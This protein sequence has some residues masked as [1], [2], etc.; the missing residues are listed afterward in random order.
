MN[1][2]RFNSGNRHI[3]P[4]FLEP[5]DDVGEDALQVTTVIAHRHQGDDGRLPYVLVIDFRPGNIE[6]LMQSG[7]DR[8]DDPSFFLERKD[9][10]ELECKDTGRHNHGHIVKRFASAVKHLRASGYQLS[11]CVRQT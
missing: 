8:F 6:F 7:Q 9:A 5:L 4:V 1:Q 2:F 10:V 11:G 3:G